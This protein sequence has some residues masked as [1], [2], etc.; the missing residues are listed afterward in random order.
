M[1]NDHVMII[2]RK[3]MDSYVPFQILGDSSSPNFD[4]TVQLVFHNAHIRHPRAIRLFSADGGGGAEKIGIKMGGRRTD[5][6]HFA[7][8]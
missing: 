1:L 8:Q 6:R 3:R 7:N 5:G 2:I 4:I